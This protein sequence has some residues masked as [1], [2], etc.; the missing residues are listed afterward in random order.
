M[1]RVREA[2]NHAER[3]K[4]SAADFENSAEESEKSAAESERGTEEPDCAM[5]VSAHFPGDSDA[6]LGQAAHTTGEPSAQEGKK[7]GEAGVFHP[8]PPSVIVGTLRAGLSP[9]HPQDS[10][11]RIISRLQESVQDPGQHSWR[12]RDPA[13]QPSAMRSWQRRSRQYVRRRW[14]GDRRSWRRG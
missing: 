14:P 9:A 7:A 5:A 11:Q 3:L 4:N 10:L 2:E 12:A 8:P 13:A 6:G 1:V